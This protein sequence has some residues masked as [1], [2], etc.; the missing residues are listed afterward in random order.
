MKKGACRNTI[1]FLFLIVC[2]SMAFA[3][4]GN[5][6]DKGKG[7]WK[8]EDGRTASV[9]ARVDVF[10]DSDRDM[11]RHHYAPYRDADYRSLPPGLAKRGGDLPPGLEKHLRRN[12][13]L[14]PGLEKKL[15]PLPIELEHRLPPLRPGLM[16]G[17]IGGSA[18]IIDKRTSLIIDVF[19]IF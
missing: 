8:H 5:G 4:N 2:S 10:V 1:V 13:H 18:V 11:I 12:G 16:R 3:G 9:S 17:M 7:K 15:Y 19:A 14:P 6:K